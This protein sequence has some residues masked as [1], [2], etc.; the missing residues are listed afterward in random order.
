MKNRI[1]LNLAPIFTTNLAKKEQKYVTL[2][3]LK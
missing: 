3:S 1:E 2:D